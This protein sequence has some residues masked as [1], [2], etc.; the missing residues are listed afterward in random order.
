MTLPETDFKWILQEANM[1]GIMNLI[2]ADFEFKNKYKKDFIKRIHVGTIHA[3]E[4]CRVKNV[5]IIGPE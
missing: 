5:T 2:Q 3:L 1:T 4:E